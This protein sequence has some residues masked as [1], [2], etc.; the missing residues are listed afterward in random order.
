MATAAS[1]FYMD[2]LLCA[3][4][5]IAFSAKQALVRALRP[6]MKR[7]RGP[8]VISTP[9]R[10]STPTPTAAAPNGG[11]TQQTSQVLIKN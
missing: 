6:R 7:R 5:I 8:A 3:D 1:L 10:C 9:P 4:P 2:L 11:V